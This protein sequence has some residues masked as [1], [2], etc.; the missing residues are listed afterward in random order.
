MITL[1]VGSHSAL[2]SVMSIVTRA[3]SEMNSCTLQLSR[4][5]SEFPSLYTRSRMWLH[6]WVGDVTCYVRPNACM[7]SLNI[8]ELAL[9]RSS[10]C[11]FWSSSITML[12]YLAILPTRRAVISSTT[13][14]WLCHCL[15]VGDIFP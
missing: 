6:L 11:I 2:L 7:V 14:H 9:V 10:T 5:S 13:L 4:L 12:L 3:W 1:S 15:V 8:Y